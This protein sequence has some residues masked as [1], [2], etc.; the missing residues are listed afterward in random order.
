MF[1]GSFDHSMDSKGRVILP[2]KFRNELGSEVVMTVGPQNC[3]RIFKSE[4]FTEMTQEM[5]RK[6]SQDTDRSNRENSQKAMRALR[7]V[8]S[9]ASDV[10]IDKQGRI[11][12]PQKMRRLVEGDGDS[13]KSEMLTFTGMMNYIELWNAE[14]YKEYLGSDED[15]LDALIDIFG[16]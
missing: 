4:D 13:N 2:A 11:L 15:S 12:I 1:Y 5:F 7:Q 16:M 3:L 9:Q 6:Y 10:P 8:M 14:E